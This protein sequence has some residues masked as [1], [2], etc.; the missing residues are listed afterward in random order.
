MASKRSRQDHPI[1][2]AASRE[3]TVE[4]FKQFPVE[5]PSIP[6]HLLERGDPEALRAAMS[7]RAGAAVVLRELRAST[8]APAIKSAVRRFHELV[9]AF[10]RH[11]EHDAA[12]LA[13]MS[14]ACKKGCSYCCHASI[15]CLSVEALTLASYVD[16]HDDELKS[17]LL[18][19]Q[20]QT[21]GLSESERDRLR[22]P[23]P[24]LVNDSCSIYHARPERCR[25]FHSF[26]VGRCRDHFFHPESEPR[27]PQIRQVGS[28]VHW[29]VAGAQAAFVARGVECE[30]GEFI[31]LVLTEIQV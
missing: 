14:F 15:Q 31:D 3:D 9:D 6:G 20:A 16:R 1:Q 8:D 18:A 24:F 4:L 21:S 17:R 26:D 19:Y 10:I 27:I 2:E 5:N 7:Y 28:L 12:K 25:S 30:K 11:E 29:I 13:K 22:L 23:C